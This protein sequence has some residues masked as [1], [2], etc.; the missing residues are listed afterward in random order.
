M[1][2]LTWEEKFANTAHRLAL[3]ELELPRL[4]GYVQTG[5]GLQDRLNKRLADRLATLEQYVAG[6][7]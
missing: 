5:E 6:L 1:A 2:L 7:K 4:Y 3:V